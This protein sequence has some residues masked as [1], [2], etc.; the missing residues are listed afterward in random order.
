MSEFKLVIIG[1]Q[2]V[3]KTAFLR[4]HSQGIFLRDSQSVREDQPEI[5]NLKFST[6][7][8]NLTANCFDISTNVRDDYLL[9]TQAVILMF[10]LTSRSSFEKLE[11][12][13]KKLMKVCPTYTPIVLVGN[14]CDENRVVTKEEILTFV[15][16]YNLHYC[17]VSVKA[18]FN[19]EKPFLYLLKKV[20][21]SSELKIL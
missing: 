14:K 13:Y 9:N 18:C 1:D 12:F 5:T 20:T 10:D 17:D 8:G 4:R 21:G 3:G 16:D 19:F 2:G 6:S 7:K 11:M 15:S